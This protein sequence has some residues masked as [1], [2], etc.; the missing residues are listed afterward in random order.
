MG[1][2]KYLSFN[3]RFKTKIIF[4][5]DAAKE[6]GIEVEA[7][8]CSRAIIV[9]DKVLSRQTDLI[10][11]VKD[12]IGARCVGV[13]DEVEPDSGVHIVDKGV[14]LGRSLNADCLVSVGGG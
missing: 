10:K 13:Y 3:F 4:G 8:K 2:D 12:A 14:D 9:T 7:L 11:R 6:A 5:A 1:Y